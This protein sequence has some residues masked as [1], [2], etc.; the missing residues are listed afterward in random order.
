MNTE[1]RNIFAVDIHNAAHKS[2]RGKQF[3]KGKRVSCFGF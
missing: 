3:T 1:I 2:G